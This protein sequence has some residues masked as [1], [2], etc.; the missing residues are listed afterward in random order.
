M[1]FCKPK[2]TED[3]P[4]NISAFGY[5][6][7]RKKNSM[8]CR[9]RTRSCKKNIESHNRISAED[10][11]RRSIF[12][13]WPVYSCLYNVQSKAITRNVKVMYRNIFFVFMN[14]PR[15]E[16]LDPHNLAITMAYVGDSKGWT[17]KRKRVRVRSLET[18]QRV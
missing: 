6:C 2:N 1:I 9:C 7:N 17:L 11:K 4:A 10:C 13:I 8:T 18:C 16:F 3:V 5:M 14:W 12:D 15:E